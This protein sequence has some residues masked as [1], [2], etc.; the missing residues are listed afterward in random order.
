MLFR[1]KTTESCY[2]KTGKKAAVR[3]SICTGEQ[4]AGFIDIATGRFDEIM[5]ITCDKDLA[6]FKK[7]Y[8]VD[9]ITRVY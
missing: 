9:E 6:K 2:D 7:K 5:L 8:D 4:V 1:R 3:H